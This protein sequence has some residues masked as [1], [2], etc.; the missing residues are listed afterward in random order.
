MLTA[1]GY[2]PIAEVQV[3]D[4][5]VTHR[6]RLRRVLHKFERET[7]EPLYVIEAEGLA[8]GTL[9]LT[10]EHKI[11][12]IRSEWV[13]AHGAYRE[14]AWIP[15]QELKVGDYVA[16]LQVR[17]SQP[18]PVA[19]LGGDA[20]L[21]APTHGT[22]RQFKQ[23]GLQW[24]QIS[25]ISTEPYIGTV[26]DIEVEEDHSFIS[27]GLVV[28]NCYVV[29]SPQDSRQ[30]IVN[31]LSQMM[32]IMSRGGGVGIN[33]SS[34]RPRYSYVKGV[35]GRS[36]GAVSWG[37]L[38]SFV[39][40]LIEQGGSRRGALMLICNDWHPDVLEFI[41]SKREA[42]KITNAN[43]SVGISD[44]FMAA[45]KADAEWDL[46]F[47]DTSVEGYDT[48]WDGDLDKWRAQG[49]PVIKYDTVRARDMWKQIIESAWASAEP[50]LWFRERAN[51]A[52]NSWYFSPLI[53][54][55]PCG[56][57]PLPAWGICNLG[58]VN[59][60]RFVEDGAVNWEKLGQT[61]RYAVR[62]LDDVI[63]A[64]PYFFEE[65]EQQQSKERRVGLGRDGV[66][67]DAD[68]PRAA[69][70]EPR[71][72]RVCRRVVPLL[73]E[74]GVRRLLRLRVGKGSLPRL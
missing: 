27:A 5:V 48:I 63:D 10:G 45:V 33:V 7:E 74:R 57:Q 38:Y 51:K 42:G 18:V 64:T 41:H 35:N 72:Q 31:T 11:L 29:P 24:G 60:A 67:G 22:S 40:G 26:L 1:E 12:V 23:E 13:G 20:A 4:F 6:N 62:F 43:I 70:R 49:H 36:S 3:G 32:E 50:G 21:P 39:T 56:E 2:K 55:N 68:P 8:E 73:R 15:A 28:S 44:A 58:A 65:N 47:P 19:M 14:A 46:V 17:Q 53:S 52:S 30:G 37:G 69:L 66:G 9:R 59:L 54:T 34:L 61:V 71:G 25:R 16:A